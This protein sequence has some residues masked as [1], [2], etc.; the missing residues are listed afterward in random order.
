[1]INILMTEFCSAAGD[2][3]RQRGFKR[4]MVQSNEEID[5]RI[6]QMHDNSPGEYSYK[7][8][9]KGLSVYTFFGIIKRGH[10]DGNK[11]ESN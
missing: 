7:G 8:T 2:D 3:A 9:D 10:T 4:T 1:M 5:L 6:N 11:T